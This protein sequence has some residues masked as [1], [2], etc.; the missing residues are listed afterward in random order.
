[1]PSFDHILSSDGDLQVKAGDLVIDDAT[2][3]HQAILVLAEKGTIRQF[4]DAG[5]GA[6]GYLLENSSADLLRETSRQCI[7]DGMTVARVALDADGDVIIDA[8]YENL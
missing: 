4:P 7:V 8:D 6:V 2:G 5:V 1:M 3:Q